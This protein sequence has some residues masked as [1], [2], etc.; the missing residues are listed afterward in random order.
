MVAAS[1]RL[2]ELLARPG[3]TLDRVMAVVASAAP[4][5]PGEETVVS[6]FDELAIR[7]GAAPTGAKRLSSHQVVT[8]TYGKLGFIGDSANYYHPDNSF[9]HRVLRRRRGI[10][11][12]L[13]AVAAEIGRRVDV[14]LSIVG[15]PGHVILGDGPEPFRWF[16]PFAGGAELDRQ[17]CVQLFSRFHPVE[18]FDEA[19]LQPIGVEAVATRMLTNLKLVYRRSG[20]LAQLLKILDL[21]VALP[22][23][24]PAER[25]ELAAMLAVT[26][27]YDRAAEQHE[28]LA[29]LDPDRATEH[30]AAAARLR[31]RRN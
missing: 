12:T 8:Y 14:E 27:R 9:I 26:G 21:S 1:E 15:L 28:I 16:D 5:P 10:P 19:M 25:R 23:S 6:A 31:A 18:A 2:A 30:L 29:T 4:H 22:D 17:R 20:D 11:L 24:G 7:L 3:T 13:A